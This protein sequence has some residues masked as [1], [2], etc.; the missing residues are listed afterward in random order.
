MKLEQIL[1]EAY[2]IEEIE[3]SVNEDT[4][5]GED[6]KEIWVGDSRLRPKTSC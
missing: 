6:Q 3:I 4:S 5:L 2:S 1:F